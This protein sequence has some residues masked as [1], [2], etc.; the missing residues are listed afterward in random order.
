MA[1]ECQ[2]PP[3]GL[4]CS[5]CVSLNVDLV[6][7][8]CRRVGRIHFVSMRRGLAACG[9]CY[10]LKSVFWLGSCGT[11]KQPFGLYCSFCVSLNVDL[12]Q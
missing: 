9:K 5:F 8:T 1:T 10:H 7:Y 11:E 4:Y 3:F 12:V 6:Q 2:K